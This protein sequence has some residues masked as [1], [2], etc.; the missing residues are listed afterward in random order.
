MKKGKRVKSNIGAWI[1]VGAGIGAALSAA[2]QQPYWVAI[3]VALGAALGSVKNRKMNH[4]Y[5]RDIVRLTGSGRCFPKV[6]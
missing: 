6:L 3:G 2:T 5:P 1:A 4:E